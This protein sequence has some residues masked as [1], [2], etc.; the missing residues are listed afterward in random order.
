MKLFQV[1]LRSKYNQKIN[2]LPVFAYDNQSIELRD[3][4]LINSMDKWNDWYAEKYQKNN[5]TYTGVLS[6]YGNGYT[7]IL[8]SNTKDVEINNKFLSINEVKSLNNEY[9]NMYSGI[10]E[11]NITPMKQD[12]PNNGEYFRGFLYDINWEFPYYDRQNIIP[13]R[14]VSAFDNFLNNNTS[15]NGELTDDTSMYKDYYNALTDLTD[16]SY[17]TNM[18]PYTL[19]YDIE[20]RIAYNYET[21][22]INAFML[23]RPSIGTDTDHIN[24]LTEFKE[25]YEFNRR[26]FNLSSNPEKLKSPYNVK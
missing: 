20:P 18:I 4:L 2:N 3:D 26:L 15:T 5:N 13:Y 24:N 11:V 22:G 17:G 7:Q 6:L 1:Y 16:S 25:K 19:L 23:R 21:K 12:E 14:I 8:E 10:N 9:I